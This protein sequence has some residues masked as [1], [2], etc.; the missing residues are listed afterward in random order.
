MQIILGARRK[1]ILYTRRK[2]LYSFALTS[3]RFRVIISM[4][5][6]VLKSRIAY[7]LKEILYVKP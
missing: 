1:V 4:Y 2:V 5:V 7:V 6:E 3:E